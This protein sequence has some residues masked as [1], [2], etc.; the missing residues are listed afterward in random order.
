[1]FIDKTARN[2]VRDYNPALA[3]ASGPD[4]TMP[5]LI[6]LRRLAMNKSIC[7]A[8][9]ASCVVFAAS[10]SV[11]LAD[12]GMMH[13]GD[14]ADRMF[15]Q[16]DAN[17]DGVVTKKEFDAFHNKWFKEMDANH[18]GKITREEMDAAH[19]KMAGQMRESMREQFKKRFDDAD[20]NHDGALS[21]E[22]AKKMP[23]VS[24]H[25]D[26]LDAN[27]DGKVTYDEIQ[28]A[29]KRMHGG[30]SGGMC[31]GMHGDAA[32][33]GGAASGVPGGMMHPDGGMM[34][35]DGMMKQ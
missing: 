25:F 9:A 19:Q 7:R 32:H 20:A 8:F 24:E 17:H 11:A 13:R 29:M 34:H 14:Y 27:H 3:A 2:S 18:D 35:K 4:T 15:E 10:V 30:Q 23:Y 33:C 1:M 12:D 6:S 26:E 16:M 22:E 21:K 28:D 31:D 5:G